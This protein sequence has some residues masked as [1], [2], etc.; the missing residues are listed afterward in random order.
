[1]PCAGGPLGQRAQLLG[2]ERVVVDRGGRDVRADE[3][4]VRAELLH[5]RELGL[6]ARERRLGQRLEVAERLVERDLQPELGGERAHLGRPQRRADQVV[7]EQF[8]GVEAGRRGGVQLLLQRAA[9]ADGGDRAA[10]APPRVAKWRSIR[11]RSGLAPVKRSKEPAA[12][13]TTIPPPSSVRQPAARASR[14]SSV[15]SGR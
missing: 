5:D 8:D 13:S 14:S 6:G 12:C 10:H 3:E 1:M 9:Q 15:S 7:L 11:S 2:G 4:R